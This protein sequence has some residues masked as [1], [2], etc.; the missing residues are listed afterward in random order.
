LRPRRRRSSG[1]GIIA[2]AIGSATAGATAMSRNT[3]R[4]RPAPLELAVPQL[5]GTEEGFRPTVVDRLRT[6][7]ADLET[8]V[9]GMYVRGLSTRDVG[10]LY[11]DTF[12][13]SRL[14]KSTVSRVTEQLNQEFETW[15]RRDL[16]DLRVV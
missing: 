2:A 15:R 12:G 10:A 5:R 3:C 13:A 7:T 14:S 8:L 9:R 16:S 11:Q 4:P 6:R 1:V